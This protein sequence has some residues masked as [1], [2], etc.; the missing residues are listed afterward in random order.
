M[1]HGR[2]VVGNGCTVGPNTVLDN[3]TVGPGSV[4]DSVRGTGCAVAPR[5]HAEPFT[6]IRNLK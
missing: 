2:T 4:L 3:C 1:L 5:T 6:A